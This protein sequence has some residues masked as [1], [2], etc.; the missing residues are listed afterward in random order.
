MDDLDDLNRRADAAWEQTLR[1]FENW[2]TI[3]EWFHAARDAAQKESGAS[4]PEGKGYCL[5]MSKRLAE[6]RFHNIDS[7]ALANLT[8]VMGNREAIEKWRATTLTQTERIAFNHPTTVWRKFQARTQVPRPKVAR[9]PSTIEQL[10]ER[11][12]ELEDEL[13]DRDAAEEPSSEWDT[14]PEWIERARRVMGTID[15]D[16]ASSEIAQQTVQAET[17]YD[18]NSDGLSMAGERLSQPALRPR[19][20]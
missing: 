13:N 18:R 19:S 9:E 5:A 12:A 15:V 6:R 20:D 10:Q 16:P 2:I 1:T 3:G 4:K 7:S 14:P 8:H 11:I 17:W